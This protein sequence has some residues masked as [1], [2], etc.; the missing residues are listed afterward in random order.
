MSY[1]PRLDKSIQNEIEWIK[2]LPDEE[3]APTIK[4]AIRWARDNIG[5][6]P[7]TCYLIQSIHLYKIGTT[8]NLERRFKEIRSLNP[9]AVIVCSSNRVGESFL[10]EYFKHKHHEREWYSLDAKDVNLIMRLMGEI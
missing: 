7:Q 4:A 6:N 5:K 2:S 9:H 10:H 1:R 3:Q 8:T